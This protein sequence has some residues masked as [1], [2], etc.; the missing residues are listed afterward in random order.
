MKRLILVV[1]TVFSIALTITACG[2]NDGKSLLEK[3]AKENK[4]KR[5]TAAKLVQSKIASIEKQFN[6]ILFPPKNIEAHTY[7]YKIQ[8]YFNKTADKTHLFSGF[9]YDVKKID[10]GYRVTGEIKLGQSWMGTDKVIINLSASAELVKALANL[11]TPNYRLR[12]FYNP[13]LIIARINSVDSKMYTSISVNGDR[14]YVRSWR[15]S[16]RR[17]VFNGELIKTLLWKKLK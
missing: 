8:D 14:D 2:D 17:L 5:E 10:K 16:H 11:R 9:I 4:S 7:A 13:H 6:G 15:E 12:K 1:V 3:K